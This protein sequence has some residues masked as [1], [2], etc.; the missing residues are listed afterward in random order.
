MKDRLRILLDCRMATW[1]GVGRYSTGLARA[2]A[3]RDD[4][5]V[6]QVVAANEVPPVS[7][8]LSAEVVRAKAHPF[9]LAGAFELGRIA[10]DVAPDLTHCLHFPTPFPAS[11]PLVVTVHDLTPIMMPEVMPSALKRFV[12]HRWNAR[13]AHVADRILANSLCTAEDFVK[14]FRAADAKLTVV[15]H[16]VDDFTTGQVGSVPAAFGLRDGESYLLSMGNPK[17]NKDLP[18]LLRAF[19]KIAHERLGL[20]VLLVGRDV[21]GFIASVID[22]ERVAARVAFTGRVD[23]ATLRALYAEASAFVFP[24]AYEGFGLP[25]L[26]A[27]TFGTPVVSSN[28]A[29][30]PEIVGDAGLMFAAGN[31][32]ALAKAIARVLD[33]PKL[34][35]RLSTAGPE[36][37]ARFTWEQTAKMTVAVYRELV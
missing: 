22:D 10:R 23:D 33:D 20:R 14:H 27:M 16:A 6:I 25:P 1:T 5:H 4:V 15:P 12:Y 35:D 2:L 26:E 9:G 18:T 31:P 34:R 32:D 36:R 21:P 7:S 29:S 8:A 37:A 30:L 19:A 3:A 24:S 28:A 13:V 11:H 17:P